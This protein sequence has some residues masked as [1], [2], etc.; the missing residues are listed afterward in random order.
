[1]ISSFFEVQLN[2]D[3]FFGSGN[4]LL[5]LCV[6]GSGK[7][8]RSKL[9]QPSWD[10]CQQKVRSLGQQQETAIK[11]SRNKSAVLTHQG[12]GEAGGS[13][14]CY[15]GPTAGQTELGLVR[16]IARHSIVCELVNRSNR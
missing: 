4:K 12:N 15:Q 11:H 6:D 2:F 9:R 16:N 3:R 8:L 10:S 13:E 14:L 5:H 1:M 7:L